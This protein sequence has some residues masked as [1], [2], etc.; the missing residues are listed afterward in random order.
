MIQK[1]GEF[2]SSVT[3][4]PAYS[5]RVSKSSTEYD[6]WE[7]FTTAN[8]RHIELCEL[9]KRFQSCIYQYLALKKLQNCFFYTEQRRKKLCFVKW[10]SI[11]LSSFFSLLFFS[12]YKSHERNVQWRN[13]SNVTSFPHSHSLFHNQRS[14]WCKVKRKFFA[15]HDRN[16]S[17]VEL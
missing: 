11:L 3:I 13:N 8:T 4:E 17:V 9:L 7:W 2:I 16:A 14:I 10:I 5:V 1:E 15:W 12:L 6:T